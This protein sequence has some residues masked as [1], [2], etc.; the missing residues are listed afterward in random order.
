MENRSHIVAAVIFIV[1]LGGGAVGFFFWL[2]TGGGE[3][4]TVKIETQHSVGGVSSGTEVKFKGLKVGH[5]D[6]IGFDP[7]DASTVRIILKVQDSVPLNTSSYAELSSQGITGMSNLTLHTPKPSA[8]PLQGHDDNPP[9]LP[10]H[11]GL[12]GKLKEQGQADL[13]K[14][15]TILDQIQKLTGDGNAR[16]ISQTLQ[17]ID[18]ATQQLTQAEKE[19]QPTLAQLPELTQQVNSTVESVQKLIHQT[20]PAIKQA[21]Q[22]AKTASSVGQSSQDVMRHLDSRVL[23]DIDSLTQQLHKTARQVQDLSAEL[24]LKPQS[25]LTGPPKRKPGPGEPGFDSSTH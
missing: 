12:L 14:I 20:I 2:T 24:S 1:I 4:R 9:Q 8:T 22:A 19:L 15:S 11:R 10:L 21:R 25:L 13:K 23:P 5:V 7:D 3:N 17:Q 16:H 18:Q 6:D